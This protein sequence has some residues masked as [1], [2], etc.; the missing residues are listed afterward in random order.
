MTL[1]EYEARLDALLT[2]AHGAEEIHGTDSKEHLAAISR[3]GE[4]ASKTETGPSAARMPGQQA[5]PDL[6]LEAGQ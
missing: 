6:D 1:D 3:Y 2:E 4:F 5:A